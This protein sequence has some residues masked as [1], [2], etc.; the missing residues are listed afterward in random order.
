MRFAGRASELCILHSFDPAARF[1]LCFRGAKQPCCPLELP[2][3]FGDLGEPL[4]TETDE[5]HVTLFP[6]ETQTLRKARLRPL[7]IT[8]SH[9]CLPEVVEILEQ[10]PFDSTRSHNRK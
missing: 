9:C 10:V 1:H 7:H 8:L 3:G 6:S 5:G 4:Q 2:P